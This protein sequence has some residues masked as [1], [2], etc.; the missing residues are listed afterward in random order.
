MTQIILCARNTAERR[1]A[2]QSVDFLVAIQ[3]STF[4]RLSLFINEQ[5]MCPTRQFASY[6]FDIQTPVVLSFVSN[7]M[8][9]RLVAFWMGVFLTQRNVSL[10]VFFAWFVASFECTSR[11]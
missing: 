4:E 1:F 6:Q 7:E 8:A 2:K 3:P 10:L 5:T 9:V 11:A